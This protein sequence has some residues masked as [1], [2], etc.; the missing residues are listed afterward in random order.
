METHTQHHTQ[1]TKTEGFLTKIRNKTRMPSLTTPIQHS[2]GSTSHSN[3]TEKAI[4]GIQIG[5]EEMKLPLF[6]DDMIVYM[7]NPIDSNEKLLKLIISEF[8]KTVGFKGNVQKLKVFLYINN[9]ISETEIRKKV[10]FDIATRKNKVPRNEPNQGGEK[11][12]LRKLHNT[13]ERN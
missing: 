1:W 5:K 10:P 12:I 2:T 9:E 6:A 11:P 7:E 8:G 13:E 3:Q 4:N